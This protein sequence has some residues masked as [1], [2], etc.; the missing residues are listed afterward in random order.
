[1][2][3]HRAVRDAATAQVAVTAERVAVR[4]G[5]V[6]AVL[7]KRC[8]TVLTERCRYK[9]AAGQVTDAGREPPAHQI[10]GG[11]QR[12]GLP[13]GVGGVLGD[14]QI[15]GV[16]QDLIQGEGAFGDGGGD[17]LGAVGAVLVGHV[18]ERGRALVH[19]VPGQRP[20]GEG[21]ASMGEALTI[22]G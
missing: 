3:G 22:G 10:E 4:A 6:T 15:G 18:S 8:R 12:Q 17:D 11:E 19:E 2:A 7:I 21:L 5:K 1:M 9:P 16:S 20:G 14:G 13:A